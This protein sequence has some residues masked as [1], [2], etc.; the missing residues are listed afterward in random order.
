MISFQIKVYKIMRLFEFHVDGF[1]R[2]V[3]VVD[4]SQLGIDTS[5]TCL[6]VIAHAVGYIVRFVRFE[7]DLL[8]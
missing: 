7:Y 3:V 2:C 1:V 5:I 8:S 6:A 4:A